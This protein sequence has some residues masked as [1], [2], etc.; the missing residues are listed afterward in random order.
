MILI[1]GV[2]VV[3]QRI[4]LRHQVWDW[5]FIIAQWLA[6][7]LHLCKLGTDGFVQSLCFLT[8]KLWIEPLDYLDFVVAALLG[9]LC[10]SLLTIGL[11]LRGQMF[12][13]RI[14]I[15]RFILRLIRIIL[16]LIRDLNAAAGL[17]ADAPI[18]AALRSFVFCS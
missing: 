8:C 15:L 16:R 4:A 6:A 1:L 5:A 10:L 17:G 7:I 11:L 3:F 9:I 2:V 18:T 13:A 14:A 12:G